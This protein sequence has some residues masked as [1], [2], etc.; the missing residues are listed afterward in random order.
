MF[1][2]FQLVHFN[3]RKKTLIRR[4]LVRPHSRLLKSIYP[5]NHFQ[6]TQRSH[7]HS[8]SHCTQITKAR[9][10]EWSGAYGPYLPHYIAAAFQSWRFKAVQ[11]SSTKMMAFTSYYMSESAKALDAVAPID[12]TQ[13]WKR[14]RHLDRDLL[15]STPTSSFDNNITVSGFAKHTAS[16]Y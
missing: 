16:I 8:Q 10:T 7:S 9:F 2:D 12:W 3:G 15:P 11:F 5:S 13:M 14:K 4:N 1:G 6:R